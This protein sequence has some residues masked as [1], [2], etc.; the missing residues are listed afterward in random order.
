MKGMYMTSKQLENQEKIIKCLTAIEIKVDNVGKNNQKTIYAL[1][2]IIAATIGV[3]FMGSPWYSIAFTYTALFAG[4]FTLSSVI[5]EWKHIAWIKRILRLTF[6]SFL[7]FSVSV[8]TFVFEAI[9]GTPLWFTPVVDCFFVILS[10]LFVLATIYDTKE[11]KIKDT[12]AESQSESI[13]RI[14]K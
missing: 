10:V 8:R 4:M 14:H 9:N 1:L 5:W 7:F 2:G 13:R 11:H 3:K 6:L 12:C